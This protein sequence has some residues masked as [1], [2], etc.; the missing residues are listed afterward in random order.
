MMGETGG[1]HGEGSIQAKV[2]QG[3]A[4]RS[5]ARDGVRRTAAGLNDRT[6]EGVGSVRERYLGC[7]VHKLQHPEIRALGISPGFAVQALVFI[8][9]FGQAKVY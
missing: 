1:A 8:L 6:G 2:T 7:P 9:S 5:I 4:A 3:Q